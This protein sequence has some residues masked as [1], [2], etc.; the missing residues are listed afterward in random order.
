MLHTSRL[1]LE[2]RASWAKRK[3][4]PV[5]RIE[6]LTSL[7]APDAGRHIEVCEA[8]DIQGDNLRRS[9]SLKLERPEPVECRDIEHA[10]AFE[11]RGDRVV[12]QKITEVEPPGCDNTVAEIDRVVPLD[13]VHPMQ[14]VFGI[15]AERVWIRNA[16]RR[17]LGVPGFF[18]GLWQGLADRTG[19]GLWLSGNDDQKIDRAEFD[20]F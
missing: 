19:A 6:K 5:F 20:A 12:M 10:F 16:R 3:P 7:C 9:A 1:T 11:R 8:V 14:Q 17:S 15:C 18:L 4:S 13:L 2:P